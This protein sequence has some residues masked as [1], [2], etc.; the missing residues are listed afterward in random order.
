MTNKKKNISFK[1]KNKRGGRG[2][3]SIRVNVAKIPLSV[4]ALIGKQGVYIASSKN[5][6]GEQYGLSQNGRTVHEITETEVELLKELSNEL[7]EDFNKKMQEA[8][9]TFYKEILKKFEDEQ[10]T[11]KFTGNKIVLEFLGIKPTN[12]D[13]K[14]KFD[15]FGD[16]LNHYEKRIKEKYIKEYKKNGSLHKEGADG[17]TKRINEALQKAEQHFAATKIQAH[18]RRF[19]QKKTLKELRNV[20]NKKR[21]KAAESKR[22]A[23]EEARN[24][25]EKQLAA[26]KAAEEKRAEEIKKRRAA[27]L[28][29]KQR[30]QEQGL[31]EQRLQ[32]RKLYETQYALVEYIRTKIYEKPKQGV[33]PNSGNL[34]KLK[35]FLNSTYVQENLLNHYENFKETLNDILNSEDFD[36]MNIEP[37]DKERRILTTKNDKTPYRKVIEEIK[38]NLNLPSKELKKIYNKTK[39]EDVEKVEKAILNSQQNQSQPLLPVQNQSKGSLQ[40]YEPLPPTQQNNSSSSKQDKTSTPVENTNRQNIYLSNLFDKGQNNDTYK[41][42]ISENDLDDNDRSAIGSLLTSKHLVLGKKI[43]NTQATLNP[44]LFELSM[45]L[46]EK[47]EIEL[48]KQYYSDEY[49]FNIHVIKPKISVDKLKEIYNELNDIIN[50]VNIS[51]RRNFK[52][53]LNSTQKRLIEELK[54]KPELKYFLTEN[55]QNYLSLGEN[56]YIDESTLVSYNDEIFDEN[57]L[58]ES[59]NPEELS[60]VFEKNYF[61]NLYGYQ[62]ADEYYNKS[63][64]GSRKPTKKQ[65]RK[66]KLPKHLRNT[67]RRKSY[68]KKRQLKTK[69]TRTRKFKK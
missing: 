57:K 15:T 35:E 39:K 3:S 5:N 27:E 17:I 47:N 20:L 52:F 4:E 32:E 6:N 24:E 62:E 46:K 23:A 58:K 38:R 7:E 16:E 68:H 29:L 42:L 48:L 67:R 54:T 31:Q 19:K 64:G 22:K 25:A 10:F 55:F 11:S 43:S 60:K 61:I 1:K 34:E 18:I 53:L 41:K 36:I 44:G 59:F 9:D 65:K 28:K 30:L 14:K 56:E 45:I 50:G 66:D 2:G 49:L 40:R 69:N 37:N 51:S 8:A 33:N 26:E 21:K 12:E 63:R 13:N